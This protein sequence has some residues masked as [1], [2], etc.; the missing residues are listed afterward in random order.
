[1]TSFSQQGA[2]QALQTWLDWA[3]TQ[4]EELLSQTGSSRTE[5]SQ[6]LK[7]CRVKKKK[8]H[9]INLN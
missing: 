2:L 3:E 7:E 5:L 4:L 1:M 8:N 6:R 9:R